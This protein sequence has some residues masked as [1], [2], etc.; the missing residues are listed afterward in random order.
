M[1]FAL[2]EAKGKTLEELSNEPVEIGN[3]V[4]TG[5]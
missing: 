1:Y 3:T 4:K 5:T 2:P